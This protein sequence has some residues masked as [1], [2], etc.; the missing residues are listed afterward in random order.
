MNTSLLWMILAGVLGTIGVVRNGF[1]RTEEGKIKPDINVILGYAPTVVAAVEQE[2]KD[3]TLPKDIKD[4]RRKERAMEM[5]KQYAAS[6]GFNIGAV[7]L[8]LVSSAIEAAV[9]M[10]NKVAKNSGNLTTPNTP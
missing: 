1:K 2:F 9:Y 7:E 3:S 8:A 4:A 6:L 5:M 10:L